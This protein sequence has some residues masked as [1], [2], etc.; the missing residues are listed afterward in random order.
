MGKVIVTV[1][2]SATGA[3]L[4]G[5]KWTH[6]G[7]RYSP[8]FG[9]TDGAG[10]FSFVTVTTEMYELYVEKE[11]YTLF[12]AIQTPRYEDSSIDISLTKLAGPPGTPT[13]GGETVIGS[14]GTSCDL[15]QKDMFGRTWYSYRNKYT[16]SHWA[17]D[18]EYADAQY[19]ASKDTGCFAPP[20]PPPMTVD[21]VSKRTDQLG[22]TVEDTAKRVSETERG[23]E[24]EKQDRS[25]G[26]NTLSGM[27][28][29][30]GKKMSA[31]DGIWDRLE[32]WLVERLVALML[33]ALDREVPE[34]KK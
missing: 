11:E 32:A 21:D 23:L 24:Q 12:S 22:K 7:T 25:S 4:L 1:R 6:T 5:A 20:P 8:L 29:A 28:D 17:W 33:R 10:Q 14:I 18:S 30:L 27:I 9:Y 19:T 34:A 13:P 16:R 15:L 31:L 2:D 26:Q 3:A